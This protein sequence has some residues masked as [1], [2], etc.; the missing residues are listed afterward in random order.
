MCFAK[1]C[2][3]K[4]FK[5]QFKRTVWKYA[6]QTMIYSIIFTSSN[7]KNNHAAG[8]NSSILKF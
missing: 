7:R 4:H 3:E 2:P 5:K 8:A 1:I 6:S